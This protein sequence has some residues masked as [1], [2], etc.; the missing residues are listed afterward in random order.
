MQNQNVDFY[1]NVN[2]L[3]GLSAKTLRLYSALEVFRGKPDS[4][5][6][7]MWFRTPE[8]DAVLNKVGFSLTDIDK[9]ITEL[10][11]AELLQIQDRNSDLWYCLK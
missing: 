11:K 1:T 8:R 5:D 9:C 10:V 7:P 4:I 2:P 3:I 6:E